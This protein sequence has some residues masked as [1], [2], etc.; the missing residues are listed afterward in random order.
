MSG[1]QQNRY[2]KSGEI[3]QKAGILTSK[4]A[5]Y[6]S[7]GLVQVARHTEGGQKLY[8]EE[9]TLVQLKRIEKLNTRGFSLEEIKNRIGTDQQI[10]RV[11]VV[12]DEPTV[13]EIITDMFADDTH[14]EVKT[15]QDGFAAG[16]ILQEYFPDL[17]ILDLR[18]PGIDGFEICKKIREDYLHYGVFILAVTG[19]DSEENYKRIIECGASDYLAKPFETHDM[20]DRIVKLLR[21]RKYMKKDDA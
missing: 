11:L 3:A 13:G 10:K 19:Y 18:L 2:L 14:I 8:A 9:D 7:L 5:Y 15:V 16:L 1:R 21:L 17:I 6:T 12:D 4:L 20:F